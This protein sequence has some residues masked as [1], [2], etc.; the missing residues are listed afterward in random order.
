MTQKILIF[1]L[2]LISMNSYS[3]TVLVPEGSNWNYLDDGSDQGT[4]WYSSEFDDTSWKLNFPAEFG[5]GDSHV[6]TVEFGD[7]SSDKYITTYF[8]TD[9]NVEDHTLYSEIELEAIRDDGIIVYLNGVEVWRDNMP[10]TS[11]YLTLAILAITGS[12]ETTWLSHIID[13]NLVT[14]TN[15]LAVEIHQYRGTTSDLSFDFRLSG[16]TSVSTHENEI[17]NKSIEV[18]PMPA[19]NVINIKLPVNEQFR[20]ANIYNLNGALVKESENLQIDVS[21]LFAGNYM[22]EV[23]TNTNRTFNELLVI[24]K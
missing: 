6:T 12:G 5:Y 23:I 18:Y 17:T 13:N 19:N 22:I 8:R 9:F 11:D 16:N 20:K 15:V 21:N 7:D 4:A 1:I 24:N 3:Q 14:G 2:L 10:D